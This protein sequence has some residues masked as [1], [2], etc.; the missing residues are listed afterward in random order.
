LFCLVALSY[1]Q[2]PGQQSDP[3]KQEETRHPPDVAPPPH[4]PE[5]KSPRQ[6]QPQQQEEKPPKAEKQAAPKPPK[7]EAKP[8]REEPNQAGRQK[9]VK[10]SGRSARI[11]D[12]QFKADFGRQHTFTVN[13]VITQ[14][15]IVP[16]QTQFVFAGYT[17]VFLDPWPAEWLLTDDC[18]I[19]FVDDEYFLFD[20]FHPGIRVALFVVG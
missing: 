16:Q 1:A 5:T 12:S 11:P 19:D 17:F 18:Y 2:Q 10:V 13:R 7:D 4:S 9:K 8:T 14:T 6:E 15:T 3:G 20:A